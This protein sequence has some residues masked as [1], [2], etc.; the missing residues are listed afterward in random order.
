MMLALGMFV[1]MRQT[2]PYQSLQRSADYRWPSNSR[3]GKRDAFQFLGPG[4][5][6]ITLSGD[7]YPE[8]TGG[9][10]SMLALYT[11][12]DEGRAWPLIS[13]TGT[14]YGMFVITNVS[15]TGTVFFADGS[16]RKIGFTLSLTRVDSSLAA[17]YGDIGKQA[18]SLVGKAGDVLSLAGG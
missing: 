8:M 18:E 6:K 5:D 1:F 4:E 12:A 15:E 17:L 11:M 2:L 3:V 13:G 9:R 7:L 14:I 10:L 16:P